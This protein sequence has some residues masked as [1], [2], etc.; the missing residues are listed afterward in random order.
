MQSS[1]IKYRFVAAAAVMCCVSG[2]LV[3][4][5]LCAPRSLFAAVDVSPSP[6][7]LL[8]SPSSKSIGVCAHA[9]TLAC[10]HTSH[11]QFSEYVNIRYPF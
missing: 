4:R 8:S 3:V 6:S 1:T 9:H 11:F 7:P 10:K 5:E 2:V